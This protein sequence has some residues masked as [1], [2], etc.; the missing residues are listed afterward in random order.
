MKDH[1]ISV[2]NFCEDCGEPIYYHELKDGREQY[3]GREC[4][5][6]RYKN[7]SGSIVDTTKPYDVIGG[8]KEE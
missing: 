7:K 8:D 6:G 1:I 4:K 5:C 3:I 2:D